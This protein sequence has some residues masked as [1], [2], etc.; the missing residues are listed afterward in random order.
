MTN[1][2]GDIIAI[3]GGGFGRNPKNPI[4]ERYILEQSQS[5]NPNICFFPTA[6]AEDKDYIDN[7]YKAFSQLDCNPKHISLFSRTPD[8]KSEIEKSDIIYIGGGNTKSMLAV[9]EEW[10]INRLLLQAYKNGKILAGVS[11]GAICWFTKGIT[12][13]WADELK[14]LNC[15]DFLPGCC[16]PHY[17]GEKD[18]RPSVMKFIDS[19]EIESCIAIE[20]GAAIH[21]KGG[22]LVNAISFYEGANIFNIYKE[23]GNIHEIPMDSIKIY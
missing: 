7:Y 2:V 10:D 4:I 23:H 5:S 17:D 16:C 3:G 13:S 11:A 20:D 19:G 15:L 1:S 8:V 9:F 14:V 6:S 22:N 21:Y 18:R 12:D